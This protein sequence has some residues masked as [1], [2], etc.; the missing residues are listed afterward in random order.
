MDGIVGKLAAA[1]ALAAL[2]AGCTG[3]APTLDV[4]KAAIGEPY[5]L[6][7]GDRL[8]VTVFNE[9]ALTGEY[10]VADNG[11]V[12]FPL[13]GNVN[14]G[15]K[16]IEQAQELLRTR[17]A[18]GYVNDPRVAVE[19]LNYRP[20]YILGEVGRSGSYPYTA[21]LTVSQAI[22]TAGGFSYRANTRRV[23]VKRVGDPVEKAVD[24]KNTDVA[25]RPGDVIRVG[26]RYF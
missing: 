23:F 12:A 8:R 1:L 9:P 3:S 17:L 16:R 26:E 7:A 25:V 21:G 5:V 24:L 15:G 13:I 14:V 11:D 6:G 4:S 22:A 19:V 20:Y 18:G 2:V 10:A